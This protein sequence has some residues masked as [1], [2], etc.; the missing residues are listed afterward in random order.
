LSGGP[1][2]TPPAPDFA[3]KGQVCFISTHLDDV[4]LSCGH[5]LAQNPGAV[6]VT[7]CAGAPEGPS[8][9]WDRLTTGQASAPAALAQRRQEDVEALRLLGA[10]PL[11][12]D[13]YDGQYDWG[14]LR[15][16]RRQGPRSIADE[17]GR[18]LARIG[19]STVV[20]PVGLFHRDHVT[21][22]DSCLLLAGDR[23]EDFYLYVDMPYAQMRPAKL[24]QRLDRLGV[25]GGELTP[26]DPVDPADKHRAAAAYTSQLR[27]VKGSSAGCFER[28]MSEAERYWRVA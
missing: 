19:A 7:V 14:E 4:V 12:L 5:F 10:T 26:V 8:G 2:S 24:E 9:A 1:A 15:S 6:V 21:V 16:V 13:L 20:A 28:S 27:W 18:A 11:W 17:V 25:A 23:A 22:S 3:P